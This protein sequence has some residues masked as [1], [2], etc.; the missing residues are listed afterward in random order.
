MVQPYLRWLVPAA[1]CASSAAAL[2][3]ASPRPARPD[4]LDARASVPRLSHESSLAQYRRLRDP[5]LIS[6]REAN[7]TVT[8]IGGWRAYAR[9][10]QPA[11][12]TP[13]SQPASAPSPAPAEV[14]KPMPS[15]H[16]G[17]KSP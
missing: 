4:P 3:Q 12:P 7:E 1:L 10:A 16:A 2:A 13:A 6:W 5:D 9:E 11:D 8:R 17:H 15:G 14:V